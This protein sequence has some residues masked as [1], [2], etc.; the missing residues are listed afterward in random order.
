MTTNLENHILEI[1]ETFLG[2]SEKIV[3]NVQLAAELIKNK[4]DS[5]IDT[6]RSNDKLIDQEEITIEETVIQIIAMYQPKAHLLRYLVAILKVNND[7]ERIS[8]LAVNM[9]KSVKV[10]VKYPDESL[11]YLIEMID[12]VLIMLDMSIKALLEQDSA[13]ALDVCKLDDEVDDLKSSQ[14]VE[15]SKCIQAEPDKV[16]YLLEII[17]NGRRLERIA[18]LCTNI[19]EDVIYIT[20]GEIIRHRTW[21][22]T[23]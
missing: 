20:D 1:K 14:R 13:L 5:R 21:D 4:D 15:V 17:I 16:N 11:Y 6:V 23:S 3:N 12:K 10:L 22:P 9:A 8:D 7:L 19:A 2:F 18:D